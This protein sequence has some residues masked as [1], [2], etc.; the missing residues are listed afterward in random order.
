[1]SILLLHFSQRSSYSKEKSNEKYSHYYHPAFR[2]PMGCDGSWRAL[3]CLVFP[4]SKNPH[5]SKDDHQTER[6]YGNKDIFH[7]SRSHTN[8]EH[9]CLHV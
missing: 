2:L 1:M 6:H 5:D 8:G 9:H 4:Y 7:V 3:I